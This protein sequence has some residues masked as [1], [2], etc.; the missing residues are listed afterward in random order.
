MCE[1]CCGGWQRGGRQYA[2]Q[3]P[4]ALLSQQLEQLK[5]HR[6]K[7]LNIYRTSNRVTDTTVASDE[8]TM[9]RFLGWVRSTCSPRALDFTIFRSTEPPALKLIED[10]TTW[11]VETRGV[12]YGTVAGYCNSLLALVQFAVAEV[13]EVDEAQDDAL[14]NALL[15]L[16]SQAEAQ[17]RDDR[18]YRPLDPNFITWADAQRTRIAAKKKLDELIAGSGRPS[19]EER[20]IRLRLAEDCCILHFLTLQPPDR[21]PD[22]IPCTALSI[23][24]PRL[25]CSWR[26]SA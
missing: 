22:P 17:H 7:I 15:I 1:C 16:R 11:L 25:P 10:F 19:R 14:V 4:S 6:T 3:K 2:L 18:R 24:T 20:A 13:L 8:G 26:R 5:E 21:V 12:T 9:L 23:N